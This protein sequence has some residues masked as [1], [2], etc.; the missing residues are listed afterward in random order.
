MG[1]K[2]DEIGIVTRTAGAI[3]RFFESKSNK[4]GTLM[5]TYTPVGL[6]PTDSGNDTLFSRLINRNSS[7]NLNQDY[8]IQDLKKLETIQNVGAY[9]TFQS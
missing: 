5:H 9:I 2:S 7:P 1:E 3:E 4:L 6:L 8:S